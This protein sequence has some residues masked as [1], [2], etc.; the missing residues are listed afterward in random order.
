[1]QNKINLAFLSKERPYSRDFIKVH[2]RRLAVSHQLFK[3]NSG[4][5]KDCLATQS[6]GH[7]LGLISEIHPRNLYNLLQYSSSPRKLRL[8]LRMHLSRVELSDSRKEVSL[9]CATKKIVLGF[10]APK[11]HRIE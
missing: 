11:S 8:S 6:L 4:L 1:M 9:L 3:R 10:F 2:T 7:G 5:I